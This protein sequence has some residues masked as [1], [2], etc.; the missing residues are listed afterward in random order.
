LNGGQTWKQA[1]A[2]AWSGKPDFIDPQNGWVI[3]DDG[4]TR[5]LMHTTD[6]GSQWGEIKPVVNP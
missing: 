3:A 6:G 4:T 1:Q 2:T 5:K